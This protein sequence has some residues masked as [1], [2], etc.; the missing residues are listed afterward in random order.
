M[1]LMSRVRDWLTS[2]LDDPYATSSHTPAAPMASD[3]PTPEPD[4]LDAETDDRIWRRV[5]AAMEA[6]RPGSVW[7]TNPQQPGSATYP[8][9]R[10]P[11]DGGR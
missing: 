1:S 7:P 4:E 5:R 11:L 8:P 10:K 9:F 6:E 3:D 2:W